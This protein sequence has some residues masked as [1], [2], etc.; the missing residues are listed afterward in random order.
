MGSNIAPTGSSLARKS[1]QEIGVV[2]LLCAPI[3][4]GDGV[5]WACR[6]W[7]PTFLGDEMR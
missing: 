5:R 6:Q 1:V 3:T 4:T 2:V 7:G